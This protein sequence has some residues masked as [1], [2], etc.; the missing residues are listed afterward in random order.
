MCGFVT[1]ICCVGGRFVA[2]S[3][4]EKNA[5]GILGDA[6]LRWAEGEIE[7]VAQFDGSTG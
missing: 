2:L 5:G 1:N 3:R 6:G 7:N 4:R